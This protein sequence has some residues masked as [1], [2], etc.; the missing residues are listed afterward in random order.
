MLKRELPLQLEDSVFWTDSTA[1][2]KYIRNKTTRFRTFVANRVSA[3]LKLS[4][5]LQLRYV[6]AAKNPADHTSRE[7]KVHYFIQNEA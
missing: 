4:E 3:I 2:L 5:P 6:N 7:L 1:V